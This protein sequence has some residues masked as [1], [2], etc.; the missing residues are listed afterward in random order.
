MAATTNNKNETTGVVKSLV[1]GASAGAVTK[2]AV[3]PLERIKILFQTQ[4]MM[5]FKEP[6]YTGILQCGAR[7]VKEEGGLALYKGNGANVLRVIPVYALKVRTYTNPFFTT[8]LIKCMSNVLRGIPVYALKVRTFTYPCFTGE[9][10][11]MHVSSRSMTHSGKWY[12]S[13]GKRTSV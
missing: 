3:A 13:L 9:L 2:T 4:A 5:G 8:K 1:A 12:V 7:V 11:K 6:K 10:I